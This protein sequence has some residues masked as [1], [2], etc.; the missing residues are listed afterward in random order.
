MHNVHSTSKKIPQKN[1]LL[2]LTQKSIEQNN[3]LL[4]IFKILQ[5]TKLLKKFKLFC[6]SRCNIKLK[7]QRRKKDPSPN[8]TEV[9]D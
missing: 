3:L 1:I 8:E 7:L 6:Q 2:V 4:Y 5:E 9:S